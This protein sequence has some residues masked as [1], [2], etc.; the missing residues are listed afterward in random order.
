MPLFLEEN[1]RKGGEREPQKLRKKES[2]KVRTKTKE[3]EGRRKL[4]FFD[5][6]TET[7][8]SSGEQNKTLAELVSCL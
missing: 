2:A 7:I 6:I 8:K 5:G 4:T 1:T 3:R